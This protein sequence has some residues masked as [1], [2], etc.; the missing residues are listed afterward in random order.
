[1]VEAGQNRPQFSDGEP[2]R[3]AFTLLELAVVVAII[4]ILAAILFP[5]FARTRCYGPTNPC[6]SN[7]KLIGLA[8]RQYAQDYNERL[9]PV[10]SR[11]SGWADL[12][13]PYAKS[14]AVFN[15]F[16]TPLNLLP[17]TDYFFNGRLAGFPVNRVVLPEKTLL[18]GEGDDDRP[19][20]TELRRFPVVALEDKT[21][22]AWRHRETGAYY[23]FADGHVQ[24]IRSEKFEA[25]VKWN[26]RHLSP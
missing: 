22:P 17:A 8:F 3:R 5:V 20:S 19:T 14:W 10:S 7:Q 24:F 9:P 13:Q 21:S 1:M 15:C 16:S 11:S 25:Q 18:L 12:L 23:L 6:Q 4:L 26:P 2:M